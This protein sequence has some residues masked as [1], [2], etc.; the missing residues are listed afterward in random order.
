[1]SKNISWVSFKNYTHRFVISFNS[2]LT[3]IVKNQTK[4]SKKKKKILAKEKWSP[5][6]PSCQAPHTH[7]TTNPLQDARR[8]L[9]TKKQI[10]QSFLC[11]KLNG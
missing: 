5:T 6:Q 1:M 10:H 2:S 8:H 4:I 9:V 3:F 7:R 11:T